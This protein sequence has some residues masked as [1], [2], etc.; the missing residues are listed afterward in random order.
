MH[1]SEK[2]DSAASERL[3]FL[4]CPQ[5]LSIIHK[6]G[7]FICRW[8]EKML[9][10][11]QKRPFGC[12]RY[13]LS[14]SLVLRLIY[15]RTICFSI[16]PISSLQGQRPFSESGGRSFRVSGFLSPHN[17]FVTNSISLSDKSYC[18][19]MDFSINLFTLTICFSFI[20]KTLLAISF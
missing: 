14:Q 7:N 12:K 6:N 15:W 9:D 1:R 3:V 5:K 8:R 13:C 16:H 11:D 20:S 10:V 18:W 2:I 19:K 17:D 4:A